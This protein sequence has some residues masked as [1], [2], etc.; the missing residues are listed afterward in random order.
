MNNAPI[1]CE[2]VISGLRRVAR[3]SYKFVLRYTYTGRCAAFRGGRTARTIRNATESYFVGK[4]RL[5]CSKVNKVNLK[6]C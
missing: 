3:S 6:F 2:R 5:L 4:K 1:E